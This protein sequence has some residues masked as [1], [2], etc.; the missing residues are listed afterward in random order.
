MCLQR[1]PTNDFFSN[2]KTSRVQP[3]TLCMTLLAVLQAD[4][5]LSAACQRS[6]AD[7]R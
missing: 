1:L 6:T 5:R 4:R 2:A 3:H 7:K